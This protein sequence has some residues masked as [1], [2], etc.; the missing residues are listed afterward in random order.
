M[1]R[2]RQSRS[3]N[4]QQALARTSDTEHNHSSAHKNLVIGL[5]KNIL[6]P[7]REQ[8]FQALGVPCCDTSAQTLIQNTRHTFSLEARSDHGVPIKWQQPLSLFA[9]CSSSHGG[10]G[11]PPQWEPDAIQD[12]IWDTR[13][14]N[15]L[16]IAQAL[17]SLSAGLTTQANI[18]TSRPYEQSQT[19]LPSL[20]GI[21][22]SNHHILNYMT[23]RLD[24]R[25]ERLWGSFETFAM[26]KQV[27]VLF[28]R[29]I[30]DF[31]RVKCR[32]MA[33]AVR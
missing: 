29:T 15:D 28:S 16:D 9:H 33:R 31:F 24:K 25:M 21:Q 3:R 19:S 5:D 13:A 23:Y 32:Q 6:Q 4:V 10:A 14:M 2:A 30:S 12:S 8:R 22:P 26:T 17:T 7:N 20:T 18:M 27:S 11:F 1:Q